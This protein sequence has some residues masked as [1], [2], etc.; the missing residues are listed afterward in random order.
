MH[1]A[2]FILCEIYTRMFLE[3]IYIGYGTEYL[4]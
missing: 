3:V 1:R 4:I 2:D